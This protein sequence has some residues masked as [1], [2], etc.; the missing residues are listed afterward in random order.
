MMEV[1]TISRSDGQSLG[2]GVLLETTL[3]AGRYV[4]FA[5]ATFVAMRA[6]YYSSIVLQPRLVGPGGRS[7]DAVVNLQGAC[8]VLIPSKDAK[9][10]RFTFPSI[11]S[12]TALMLLRLDVATGQE[13]EALALMCGNT[14]SAFEIVVND[15]HME[16]MAY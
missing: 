5:K 4:V 15:C 11:G 13:G 12:G 14:D 3:R 7:D 6:P 10:A 16:I 9:M 8:E 1:T 2:D